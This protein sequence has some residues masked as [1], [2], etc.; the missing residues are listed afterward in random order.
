MSKLR[1][2][3]F[4]TA[5]D[6]CDKRSKAECPHGVGNDWCSGT[7][8][9]KFANTKLKDKVVIDTKEWEEICEDANNVSNMVHEIWA[10]KGELESLRKLK[11]EVD[12]APT[13]Y[14]FFQERMWWSHEKQLEKDTHRAKLVRIEEIK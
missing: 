8:W 2:E 5:E 13:H 9:A 11:A 4:F 12:A 10:L 14:C 1:S 6:F 7:F 3:P